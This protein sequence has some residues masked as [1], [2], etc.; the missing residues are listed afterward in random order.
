MTWKRNTPDGF[1]SY[2]DGQPLDARDS[3]D[4]DIPKFDAPVYF[5]AF[6]GAGE[7]AQGHFDEIA[8]WGRALTAEDIAANWNRSLTGDEPDL[9]G[10]WDFDD[11]TADDRSAQAN[12]GV[13][14]GNALGVFMPSGS[15]ENVYGENSAIGNTSAC[16]TGLGPCAGGGVCDL[17]GGQLWQDRRRE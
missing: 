4:T 16:G 8:I 5:G 6:N 14:N 2:F 17:D 7:F 15:T 12:H 10:Y 3:E 1:A 13:L 11:G 9:V